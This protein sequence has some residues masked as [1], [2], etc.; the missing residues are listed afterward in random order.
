MRFYCPAC[1]AD[2]GEDF[3]WCPHC[4]LDVREFWASKDYVEKLV[5]ALNHP[6]K[7]TPIRAAWILGKLRDPKAVKALIG[8]IGKTKDVYLAVAAVRALAEIGTHDAIAFLET[9]CDH[10]ARMVREAAR[11][12]LDQDSCEPVNRQQPPNEELGR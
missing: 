8:L 11:K 9:V 5:L 7:S 2:F 3:D 1:W 6:E 10:P 4:G 12:A